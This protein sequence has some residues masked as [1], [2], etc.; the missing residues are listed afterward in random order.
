[1]PKIKPRV[2]TCKANALP[3]MWELHIEEL[4]TALVFNLRKED[5]PTKKSRGHLEIIQEKGH[6]CQNEKIHDIKKTIP[7]LPTHTIFCNK[8][9]GG[10]VNL[11]AAVPNSKLK[12]YSKTITTIIIF[13]HYKPMNENIVLIF[14][15]VKR[16][17][18]I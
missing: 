13:S 15:Y 1:M 11:P 17:E 12:L 3:S 16:R 2:A 4:P 7:E 8:I 5:E 10:P 6:K 9:C 14:M 18:D